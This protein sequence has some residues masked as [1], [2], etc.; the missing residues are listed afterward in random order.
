MINHIKRKISI[1]NRK[2][3]TEI[4]FEVLASEPNITQYSKVDIA[5]NTYNSSCT[6][7]EEAFIYK[8]VNDNF[9]GNYSLLCNKLLE[10][11]FKNIYSSWNHSI[12]EIYDQESRCKYNKRGLAGDEVQMGVTISHNISYFFNHLRGISY[13]NILY[14]KFIDEINDT[15]QEY[16]DDY[17]EYD[18]PTTPSEDSLVNLLKF[19]P[20]ISGFKNFDIYIE[21]KNGCFGLIK[22][23]RNHNILNMI[24]SST[25]TIIYSVFN[26]AEGTV[27]FSGQAD[28]DASLNNSYFIERLMILLADY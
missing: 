13:K 7:V 6:E 16:L 2:D 9:S 11:H 28:F 27:N 25:N 24:F 15:Y 1:E 3:W 5:E 26:E 10:N 21:P 20:T 4:S 23:S 14:S 17:E 12:Y 19:I 18:N 22:H 8:M